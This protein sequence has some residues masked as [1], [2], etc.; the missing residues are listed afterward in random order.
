MDGELK[1]ETLF[2]RYFIKLSNSE[3]KEIVKNLTK[4]QINA[5]SAIIYNAIKN[6]FKIKTSDLDELKKYRSSLYAIVNKKT[7]LKRKR[8]LIS[9]RIKQVEIILNE[10]LKRIP[11]RS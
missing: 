10:G 2:L 7:A 4:S 5:I 11:L 1:K 9:R 8:S 6:T 3:K